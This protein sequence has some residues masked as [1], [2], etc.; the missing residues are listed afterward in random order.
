MQRNN[1]R[2]I[3]I[4]TLVAIIA[5]VM[6]VSVLASTNLLASTYEQE[7]A[8]IEKKVDNTLAAECRITSM[9]VTATGGSFLAKVDITYEYGNYVLTYNKDALARFETNDGDFKVVTAYGNCYGTDTNDHLYTD[10]FSPYYPS[11][12]YMMFDVY[13][14]MRD[15]GGRLYVVD[16]TLT[17][18]EISQYV[19]FGME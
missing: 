1:K 11:R 15:S 16:S 18:K 17:T 2:I 6:T 14:N 4:I 9:L 8:T 19:S 12:G 3:I 10:Y 7:E 5:S 13:L